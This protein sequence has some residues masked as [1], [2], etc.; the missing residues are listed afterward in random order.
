MPLRAKK[1]ASHTDTDRCTYTHKNTPKTAQFP[2]HLN[3]PYRTGCCANTHF[4]NCIVIKATFS[5]ERHVTVHEA[6]LERECNGTGEVIDWVVFETLWA[7]SLDGEAQRVRLNGD[8]D[9]D[10]AGFALACKS[11]LFGVFFP[12]S[13]ALDHLTC[14]VLERLLRS[15][16]KQLGMLQHF[17]VIC[18][19]MVN[20]I[21]LCLLISSTFGATETSVQTMLMSLVTA[22]KK[23]KKKIKK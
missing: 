20:K 13:F 17:M 15:H 10:D 5:R 3:N 8:D 22:V 1:E 12:S 19:I 21:C 2:S 7:S 18:F 14:N 23:K 11:I 6:M 9:D 16:S 4:A